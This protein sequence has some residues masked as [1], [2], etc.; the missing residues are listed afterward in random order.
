MS[1]IFNK[2]FSKVNVSLGVLVMVCLLLGC[3]VYVWGQCA[4]V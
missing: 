2:M 4:L 3:F 1:N